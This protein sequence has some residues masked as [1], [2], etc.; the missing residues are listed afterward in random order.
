M[1]VE[2]RW[3]IAYTIEPL[4]DRKYSKKI[5]ITI[6]NHSPFLRSFKIST[7]DI[8]IRDQLT[9]LRFRMYYTLNLPIILN[10]EKYR[11]ENVEVKIPRLEYNDSDKIVISIEN[12]SKREKKKIEV[13][14]K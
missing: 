9:N 8:Q 14:L 1:E 5:L 10:I 11:K 4:I 2:D 13:Y 6:K 7:E 12:I 3:D